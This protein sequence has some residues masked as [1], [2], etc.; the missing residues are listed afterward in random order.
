MISNSN[1]L[2]LLTMT[3]FYHTFS[4]CERYIQSVFKIK[5]TATE[6]RGVIYTQMYL[7]HIY[8]SLYEYKLKVRCDDTPPT[9][10]E[11]REEI[12]NRWETIGKHPSNIGLT[13]M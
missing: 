3:F 2:N 10:P 7:N 9:N 12:K 11:L 5:R 13:C 8:K 1:L 6:K 4:F